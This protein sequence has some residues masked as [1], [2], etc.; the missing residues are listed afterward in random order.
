M[1]FVKFW[2]NKINYFIKGAFNINECQN[3][4]YKNC[5]A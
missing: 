4:K 2:Q 5:Q 1:R 3:E